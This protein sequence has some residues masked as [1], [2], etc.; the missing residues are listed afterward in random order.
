MSSIERA[1]LRVW[2]VVFVVLMLG[3]SCAVGAALEVR[4]LMTGGLLLPAHSAGLLVLAVAGLMVKV[5]A[6]LALPD[7]HLM[8]KECK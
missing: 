8:L 7:K 3:R 2:V 1:P 6:V 4:A 5:V